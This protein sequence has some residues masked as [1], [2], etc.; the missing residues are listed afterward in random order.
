MAHTVAQV[1]KA[2]RRTPP[3]GAD[4]TLGAPTRARFVPRWWPCRNPATGHVTPAREGRI[5][6]TL[7]DG[8]G[9][10]VSAA[11]QLTG[12]PVDHFVMVDFS[13]LVT[14]ADAVGGVPV[15]V[16]DD[17]YDS[18][19]HLKLARGNHVVSGQAAL[20]FLRSR[21]ALGDG[22]DLAAPTPST[23]TWRPCYAPSRAPAR[24]PTPLGSTPW[25]TPQPKHSRSTPHWEASRACSPW[26][27]T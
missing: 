9:C 8:P 10:Q 3:P 24:W 7:T 5:N 20:E 11:H 14:M 27:R 2:R 23:C 22:S 18:Q 1:V 12:I 13:G 15:C 21:H 16:S 4:G 26:P 17:I 19:S 25:P 6:S